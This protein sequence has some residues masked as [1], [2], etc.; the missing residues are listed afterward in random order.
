LL[1]KSLDLSYTQELM[2]ILSAAEQNVQQSS[3]TMDR[4]MRHVRQHLASE[5]RIGVV[6]F[7]FRVTFHRL[8]E[9]LAQGR[10][11]PN[12]PIPAHAPRVM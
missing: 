1:K 4:L 10:Q 5:H 9:R 11:R 6:P 3:D 7:S 12:L 8:V 2:A